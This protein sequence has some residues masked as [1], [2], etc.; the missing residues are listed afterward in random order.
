MNTER[1]EAIMKKMSWVLLVMVVSV[2]FAVSG[3][4]QQKNTAL[5]GAG[6]RP[7]VNYQGAYKSNLIFFRYSK[8]DAWRRK[9]RMDSLKSVSCQNALDRLNS[10]GKWQG[11]LNPDGSCG[12][13]NNEAPE[14]ATGNR[15]N[16]D[17]ASG[18]SSN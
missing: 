6:Y 10:I 12:G 15:I 8:K 5:P 1:M 4:A 14:W 2:V 7:Q 13:N 16:Y 11:N 3:V 9:P 18:R 17:E